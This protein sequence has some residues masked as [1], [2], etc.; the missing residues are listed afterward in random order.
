MERVNDGNVQIRFS[1]KFSFS[2][3]VKSKTAIFPLGRGVLWI[4]SS[5]KHL[6]A[7]WRHSTNGFSVTG[8]MHVYVVTSRPQQPS[9]QGLKSYTSTFPV[10]IRHNGIPSDSTG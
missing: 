5:E 7:T 3:E 4:Y 10:M 9:H 8:K 6:P 2:L 1:F